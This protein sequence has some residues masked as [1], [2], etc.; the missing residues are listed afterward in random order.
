VKLL[1][2][3]CLTIKWRINKNLWDHKRHQ[4]YQIVHK[5][6]IIVHNLKNTHMVRIQFINYRIPTFILIKSKTLQLIPNNKICQ[7]TICHK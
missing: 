6:E 4:V 7:K 2:F 1:Q 3:K 5:L